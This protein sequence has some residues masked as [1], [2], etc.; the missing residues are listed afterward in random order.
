MDEGCTSWEEHNPVESRWEDSESVYI[1]SGSCDIQPTI[2]TEPLCISGAQNSTFDATYQ[3][4]SVKW[5]P[6]SGIWSHSGIKAYLYIWDYGADG[7]AWRIGPSYDSPSAWF[8]C[9]TAQSK[10]YLLF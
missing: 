5:D 3:Y 4:H 8:S 1:L 9:T 10:S 2:T 6:P 7:I